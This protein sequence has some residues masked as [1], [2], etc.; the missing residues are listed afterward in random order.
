MNLRW[1]LYRSAQ[2][3]R[4]AATALSLAIVYTLFLIIIQLF[5]KDRV[6]EAPFWPGN[7][8]LVA[9]ILVLP[10]RT[11]PI[12]VVGCLSLNLLGSFLIHGDMAHDLF[13][14]V[15]DGFLSYSVAVLTRMCRAACKRDPLSGVIG[16]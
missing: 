10:R 11:G 7:G 3:P 8:I 5:C 6:G 13:Y 15:L 12:F 14:S 16:A 4:G 1:R 9:G 2:R